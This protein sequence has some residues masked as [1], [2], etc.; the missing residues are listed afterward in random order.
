MRVVAVARTSRGMVAV[1]EP[2][3]LASPKLLRQL[4]DAIRGEAAA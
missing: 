1:V 2:R 4:A 3:A